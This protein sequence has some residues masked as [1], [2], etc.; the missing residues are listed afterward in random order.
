MIQIVTGDARPIF[1]Q[2]AD[3]IRMKVATGELLPGARLPSVRGLALQL[4]INTTTVAKAYGELASEGVIESRQGVGVFVLEPRQ[5][6]SDPE[7][8]RRLAEALQIFV[9]SVVSLGFDAKEIEAR[10]AQELEPLILR[11]P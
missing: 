9:S 7:R 6:L 4:T 2:I 11:D 10:L 1:R 5:R 8:E 3:G